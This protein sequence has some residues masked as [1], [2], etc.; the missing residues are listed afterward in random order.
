MFTFAQHKWILI[1]LVRLSSTTSD[2]FSIILR[3][4]R[5]CMPLASCIHAGGLSC[6]EI[7]FINS[8]VVVVEMG[9]VTVTACGRST[10]LRRRG[11]TPPSR[12]C[13]A[14]RSTPRRSLPTR[15]ER[16]SSSATDRGSER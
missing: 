5:D 6:F 3:L 13:G 7:S 8:V 15:T 16:S 11:R 10:W 12:G 9:C 14:T 1:A 2:T 4:Q